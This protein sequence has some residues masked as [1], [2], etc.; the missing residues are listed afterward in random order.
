M[1]SPSI[2]QQGAEVVLYGRSWILLAELNH[3]YWLACEKDSELPAIVMCVHTGVSTGEGN[4]DEAT[5]SGT[6]EVASD[7]GDGG[8]GD[9]GSSG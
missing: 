1:E 3:G 9:A 2:L 6:P 4:N 8:E 5:G 7:A